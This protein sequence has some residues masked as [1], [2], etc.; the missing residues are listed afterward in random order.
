MMRRRT[1]LTVAALLALT[2]LVGG[3]YNKERAEEAATTAIETRIERAFDGISIGATAAIV[4]DTST[5]RVFYEKDAD[6]PYPLASVTK[7]MTALVALEER[8]RGTIVTVHPSA[9]AREGDSGLYASERFLLPDLVR[10]MLVVSSNDAAGAIAEATAGL[11]DAATS[12][13][14]FVDMMNE[15][16]AEMGLTR[17]YF[18]NESGLDRPEGGAGAYGS[19]R[20]VAL[21]IAA[22]ADTHPEAV[23]ATGAPYIEI[24]SENGFTHRGPNTNVAASALPG[25]VASKTGFTELAG[26]NLAVLFDAGLSRRIAVVVLG[27]TLE[28]RFDDVSALVR[29]SGR[30]FETSLGRPE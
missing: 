26:G 22:L 28:G 1:L 9:L 30:V 7:L 2:A 11:A 12:A 21:L 18:A 25:L 8:P 5:G 10:F 13:Q 4:L 16:A 20:D 3:F 29:A 27:S 24:T 23:S 17:T 19:A 6:A 14:R 15:R